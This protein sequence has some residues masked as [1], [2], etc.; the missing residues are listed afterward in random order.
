MPSALH[1]P[2]GPAAAADLLTKGTAGYNLL[3]VGHSGRCVQLQQ[4]HHRNLTYFFP[5]PKVEQDIIQVT[6]CLDHMDEVQL[7][8]RV[9]CDW[10][11]PSEIF[12]R[13]DITWIF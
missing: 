10:N 3:L 13:L 8:Y 6:R 1:I 11:T 5:E 9:L 4:E 7:Y 12:S 2:F